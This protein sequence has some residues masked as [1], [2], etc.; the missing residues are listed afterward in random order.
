MRINKLELQVHQSRTEMG[1]AAAQQV[2]RRINE[3]LRQ[4]ATVNIIFAAAPSQQEFLQALRQAPIEWGRIRAFHMD[5]YIGLRPDAVQGFGNFLRE[6]LFDKVPFLAV[7]YING[8][9]VDL[10][11]ECQRYGALLESFPPD[12]VCMGIGENGHIA[13]NDPPTA[14]FDD[15]YA[16]KVVALDQSCRQQQVNDG[17]FPGLESV[18]THAITLT[19]PALMS[20]RFI[21]CIVPGRSKAQAVFNTLHREVVE[22]YPASI[23]RNHEH[24]ILFLDALSAEM[25]DI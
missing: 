2:T 20:G 14:D 1:S 17:C 4:Q 25:M 10:R 23:L 21:Y 11:K 3:L 12:I 18:P 24:A 22:D 8:D 5:E 19:I 16:V 7:Y 15:P 9:A 6:R 13:F